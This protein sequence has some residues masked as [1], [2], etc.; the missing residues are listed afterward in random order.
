MRRKKNLA[1]IMAMLIT[2]SS[3]PNTFGL[4]QNLYTDNISKLENIGVEDGI[5][6][7]EN[8][9]LYID[10][11]QESV[12]RKYINKVSKIEVKD[13]KIYVTFTFTEKDIIKN[14]KIS[15]DDK[16]I[17]HE[18]LNES[19]KTIDY[20]IE[21]NSIDNILKVNADIK[22]PIL[23]NPMNVDFRLALKKDTLTKVE[24]GN[25]DTENPDENQGGDS[26]NG[27]NGDN[28]NSND[29]VE[30]DTTENLPSED[31][32]GQDSSDN[33]QNTVVN[34]YKTG[35]YKMNNKVITDS[36]I[37]YEAARQSL[38][39]VNYME[40]KNNKMYITLG[41][42]QTDLMKN[43]RVNVNG[44][45]VSYTTVSKDSSKNTMDI[46]FEVL[47]LKS[48]VIIKAYIPAIEQDISFGVGFI[49]S[50][51]VKISQD[52]V[53]K[54]LGTEV[55][56]SSLSNMSDN[57]N[58]NTENE[59]QNELKNEE[60]DTKLNNEYEKRYSIENEVIHDSAIGKKMARKY[61]YE[62]SYIDIDKD[63]QKYLTITFS[64]TSVMDDFKIKVNGQGVEF[65]VVDH[66][67]GIK[68]FRFKIDEITDKIQFFMFIKP[69][70]MDIGF[71]IKLLEDT[72][73]LV[74]ENE[75]SVESVVS[76]SNTEEISVFKIVLAT[77]V[78][79]TIM[80]S[81]VFLIG[82]KIYIKNKNKNANHK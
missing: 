51:V 26:D 45:N 34:G 12:A 52:T 20:K 41:F 6:K 37:G 47:S 13:N 3:A 8:D 54:Q 71:E 81:A 38:N 24:D 44:K 9:A 66:G 39:E 59:N 68:S 16:E 82:F 32:S 1:I 23:P 73:K 50:S 63:E 17:P 67:D 57:L 15:L 72:M 21:I 61:L 62:T 28:G 79:T 60:L 4:E 7:I 11:E 70:K 25:T 18:I 58:L 42:G 30:D 35:T 43:I 74:D 27:A 46:K 14:M 31:N 75:V 19:E 76:N 29:K 2:L 69:V 53:N 33:N 40:V 5:Y 55:T 36:K 64:G 22:V 56:D 80:V 10:K 78:T 49:E 65:K 77:S 48:D